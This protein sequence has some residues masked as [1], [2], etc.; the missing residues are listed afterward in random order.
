MLKWMHLGPKG[1]VYVMAGAYTAMAFYLSVL[2]YMEFYARNWDMGIFQQA[3]WST[4]HGRILWESGDYE[5]FGVSSFF[6]IHP[7]FLMFPL[8][9]LYSMAPWPWTLLLLQAAFTGLAAVPLFYLA[10]RITASERKGLFAAAIYLAWAPILSSNLYDFHLE[11]FLPVELFTFFYLWVSRHYLAAWVVATTS[12]L[13]LELAPLLAIFF[14]LFIH[15]DDLSEWLARARSWI[16]HRTL[17][18]RKSLTGLAA[19][20][21]ER[22]PNPRW[23]LLL[24]IYAVAFYVVLRLLQGPFISVILGYQPAVA[25]TSGFSPR[26]LGLSLYYLPGSFAVKVEYWIIL[27]GLLAFIPLLYRRTLILVVPWLVWTFMTPYLNTVHLGY[28]YGYIAAIPLLIGFC[29]GLKDLEDAIGR[30]GNFL[31]RHSQVASAGRRRRGWMPSLVIVI[32][33]AVNLAISPIDP[34]V[35]SSGAYDSGTPGYW[36]SYDLAPGYAPVVHAAELIQPSESYVLASD[37]L[38]VFVANDVHA[39]STLD[40]PGGGTL[41]PF[42]PTNLPT[43]LFLSEKDMGETPAFISAVLHNTS[44][45]HVRA[46]VHDTPVGNVTLYYLSA[47][48]VHPGIP[49]A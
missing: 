5:T 47:S 46:V 20:A 43:Y 11:S 36:V 7:S 27:Y 18:I 44:Y 42:D 14:L 16:A 21:G 2:R 25:P 31:H 4:T 3:L 48:A 45:Y 10:R 19:Q 30:I 17:P 29:Y 32:L 1:L 39:Y 9:G 28:S 49:Y 15:W 12:F 26:S 22:P 37:D 35:Q 23:G 34:L 41:G 24:A 40:G 33:L 6:Q 38:F 13:T 8:A